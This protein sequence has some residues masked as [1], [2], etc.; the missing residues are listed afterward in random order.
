MKA[1]FPTDIRTGPWEE[2][3]SSDYLLM[4]GEQGRM[5]ALKAAYN[6]FR[7]SLGRADLA[8]YLA[9]HDVVARYR[10]SILGPLWITLSMAAMIGGIGLLYAQIFNMR[11]AEYVPFLAV[12]VVVWGL[13]S[14][15]IVESS[16]TFVQAAGILRQTSL[17]VF[18]F[19]WRT[20]LRNLI[21]LAHHVL[22]LVAVFLIFGVFPGA[23]ILPALAGLLLVGLNLAWASMLVGIVSARFRDVPQIVAAAVQFMMFVTP[24]FWSPESLS[25]R[26][27]VLTANPFYYML[28]AVRAPLLGGSA[29]AQTHLTLAALALAG[30]SV[31]FLVFSHLRRRLVHFL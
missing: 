8:V 10:G 21:Y 22:I 20:L 2:Q 6:D 14:T 25:G 30:W 23:R 16:D 4:K 1:V 7:Q 11:T 9:W 26:P 17:P 5:A 18:L 13:I 3:M 31:S 29:P 12:G 24:V 28:E 19:T 27:A 15:T